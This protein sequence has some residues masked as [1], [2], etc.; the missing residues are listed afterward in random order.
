[1]KP[2]TALFLTAVLFAFILPACGPSENQDPLL[3]EGERLYKANCLSCHPLDSS[4]PQVGPHLVGLGSEMAAAGLD[5]AALLEESIRQ[6]GVVITSGYQDLMPAAD[7]L[8]L[9]DSD[10][11]ALVAYLLSLE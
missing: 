10:I 5:A 8:G 1:M 6:P 4:Q 3:T 2:A 7:V 11:D 9:S